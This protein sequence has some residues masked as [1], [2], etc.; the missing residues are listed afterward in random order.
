MPTKKLMP[1]KHSSKRKKLSKSI[2]GSALKLGDMFSFSTKG[3]AKKN[4]SSSFEYKNF[5]VDLKGNVKDG[6][7]KLNMKVEG[8][9]F[10]FK[11]TIIISEKS[12]TDLH[13]L[14]GHLLSS[15]TSLKS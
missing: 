6:E 14:F 5:M 3:A 13:V 10:D 8:K 9:D 2:K 4:F 12:F 7:A 15:I 11:G 1:K